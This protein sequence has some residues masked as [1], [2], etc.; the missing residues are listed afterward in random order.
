MALCSASVQ[1]KIKFKKHS[2][3]D[4]GAGFGD[5]DGDEFGDE[6]EGNADLA[7]MNLGKGK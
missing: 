2:I 6:F 7:D 3:K 4:G 1:N 5:D